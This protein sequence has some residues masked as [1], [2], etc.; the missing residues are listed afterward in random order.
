MR[1]GSRFAA[2][3][4]LLI[5]GSAAAADLSVPWVE[6]A[7]NGELSVRTVVT[8]DAACPSISA[9]GATRAAN[10]RGMPDSRFP[11]EVCEARA[12]AAAARLAVGGVA[13]PV[14]P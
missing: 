2:L 12:P 9:D 4:G 11:V 3:I 1:I 10:R 7:A 14:L 8:P 5:A 13:V 6:L